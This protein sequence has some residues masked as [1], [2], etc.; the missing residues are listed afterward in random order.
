MTIPYPREL[1]GE[2]RNLYRPLRQRI[3]TLD[4]TADDRHWIDYPAQAVRA[5]LVVTDEMLRTRKDG[6]PVADA[7]RH[8]QDVIRRELGG[9]FR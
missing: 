8:L 6:D 9:P 3:D 1:Q 5:V 7:M 4:A 2:P